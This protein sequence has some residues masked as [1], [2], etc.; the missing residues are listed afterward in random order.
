MGC[1][2]GVTRQRRPVQRVL[3]AAARARTQRLAESPEERMRSDLAGRAAAL[4]VE[5]AGDGDRKQRPRPGNGYRAVQLDG[6]D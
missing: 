3:L 4:F 5:R 6:C 2:R 1:N